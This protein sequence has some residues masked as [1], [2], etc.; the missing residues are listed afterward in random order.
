VANRWA[1]SEGEVADFTGSEEREIPVTTTPRS[2]TRLILAVTVILALSLLVGLRFSKHID[3]SSAAS[4]PS[5]P[6]IAIL[7]NAPACC[8]WI[9]GAVAG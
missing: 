2:R 1:E 8:T 4:K 5:Q 3:A 9:V 7:T 6:L